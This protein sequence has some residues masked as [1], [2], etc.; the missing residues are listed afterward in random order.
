MEDLLMIGMVSLIVGFAGFVDSVAGGGGIIALPAYFITGLPAHV[1]YGTN[2]FS[3]ACGT[4]FATGIYFRNGAVNLRVAI[5]AAVG[6]FI[7]ST[8]GSHIV[9]MLDDRMLK[10]MLIVMLPVMAIVI[11]IKKIGG[12]EDHSASLGQTKLLILGFL[13]GALVGGYDGIFGPGTGTIAAI[14]FTTITRFDLK[15]ASGNAKVLNLASNVA[16][17]ITFLF[18]GVIDFRYGIPAAACNIAGAILGSRMAVKRGSSFIRPMMIAVVIMLIA[19]VAYDLVKE[20][21]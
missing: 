6:S 1:C 11:F 13:V 15:T 20:V 5:M 21:L 4:A 17:L 14:A 3:S 8:I 19:K 2:K 7:G 12:E 10:L 16:A 9:L 18:A